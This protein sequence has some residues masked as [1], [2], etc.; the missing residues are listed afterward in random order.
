MKKVFLYSIITIVTLILSLTILHEIGHWLSALVFYHAHG[1]LA[2]FRGWAVG[3]YS[4]TDDV[5]SV[6]YYS[7]GIFASLVVLPFVFVKLPIYIRAIILNFCCLSFCMGIAEGIGTD[8]YSNPIVVIA[9]V[10]LACSIVIIYLY[11]RMD[12]AIVRSREIICLRK[13]SE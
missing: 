12:R 1:Q 2:F 5:G 4:T 11:T 9:S 3:I 10:L 6:V 8:A 13:S 7:G